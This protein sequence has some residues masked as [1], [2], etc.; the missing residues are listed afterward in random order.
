M[1]NQEKDIKASE[2]ARKQRHLKKFGKQVQ[3]EKAKQ[4]LEE[5]KK[6]LEKVS[7]LRK[8][9]RENGGGVGDS[10]R[11]IDFDVE[12]VQSES[13][14]SSR[15]VSEDSTFLLIH[16]LTSF[17]FLKRAAVA[18]VNS[19]GNPESKKMKSMDLEGPSDMLNPILAIL[20]MIY[21]R[22]MPKR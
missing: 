7:S 22:L 19:M 6:V 21:L 1:L 17:L 16:L 9:S 12:T 11:D 2:E 14:D 3:H 8:K 4:R 5:K 20:P 18:A 15:G 10:G 13:R